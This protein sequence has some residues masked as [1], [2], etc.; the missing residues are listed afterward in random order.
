MCIVAARRVRSEE[1]LK[2]RKGGLYLAKLWGFCRPAQTGLVSDCAR[3]AANM[4]CC[5]A[6]WRVYMLCHGGRLSGRLDR[7]TFDA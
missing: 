4:K 2:A 3:R 5:Q 1:V 6:A 7:L